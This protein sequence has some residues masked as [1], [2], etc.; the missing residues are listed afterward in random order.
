M[1]MASVAEWD[2][3]YARLARV[4]SQ[5][6]TQGLQSSGSADPQQLN[7]HLSRL[8]AALIS[9]PLPAAE[10]QRRRRLIQGLK[11]NGAGA[12][13]AGYNPPQQGG[14][15]AQPPQQQQQQS[16]MQDAINRQ[17]DMID[18]LAIGVS[19]LR[20]Q[21][22]VIGDEARMHVNLLNDMESNLDSAHAGLEA[23]TRRAAQLQEDKSVWRLQLTVAGLSV[24]LVLLLLAGIS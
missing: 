2:N 24:L 22:Q 18:E 9:L 10:V 15:A 13:G 23:E 7:Q 14:G 16:L 8:D 1:P 12:A 6:R 21:T 11:T 4:S 19:R 20:D 17:D 5:M 3:E